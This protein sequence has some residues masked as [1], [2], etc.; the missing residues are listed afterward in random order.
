MSARIEVATRGPGAATRLEALCL[1]LR[2]FLAG[3]K[4]SVDEEMRGYPT[5]IPRCDAQFNHLYELRSRLAH[6][7][8]RVTAMAM[9]DED[10]RELVHALAEFAASAPFTD[11]AIERSLRERVEIELSRL[12]GAGAADRGRRTPGTD[13]DDAA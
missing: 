6:V 8:G 12:D 9:L 11:D 13:G 1:E 7:L 3:A 10:S 4:K 2:D 5:P